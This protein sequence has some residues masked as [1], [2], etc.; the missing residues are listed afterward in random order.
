MERILEELNEG[1]VIVDD[2]LPIVFA[3]QALLRL[4]KATRDDTLGVSPE[5]VFP[6]KDIPEIW[7]QHDSGQRNGQHR[8][9]FYLPRKD[10]ERIPAI[11]GGRVIQGPDGEQYVLLIVY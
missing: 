2:R 1:V 4:T 10:G 6:P 5:R 7:R 11:F 9:E 8:S 3:N